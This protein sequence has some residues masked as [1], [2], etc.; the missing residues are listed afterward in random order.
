MFLGS[1]NGYLQTIKHL[2]GG[3]RAATSG[4]LV[5][6]GCWLGEIVRA[7]NATAAVAA[8]LAP[9]DGIT[10]KRGRSFFFLCLSD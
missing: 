8:T 10:L 2:N 6:A 9:L 7:A 5:R 3:E 4:R 1:D